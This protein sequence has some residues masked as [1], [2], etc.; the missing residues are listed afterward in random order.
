M[1]EPPF[2]SRQKLR[3]QHEFCLLIIQTCCPK[4]QLQRVSFG[5]VFDQL[6]SPIVIQT[7][8]HSFTQ[9]LWIER[10]QFFPS[11]YRQHVE[12]MIRVE[13]IVWEEIL[14]LPLSGIEQGRYSHTC[15]IKKRKS[16]SL[17]T[18]LIWT[19]VVVV[20]TNKSFETPKTQLNGSRVL[21]TLTR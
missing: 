20:Q 18:A 3:H 9:S 14:F 1:R 17:P 6:Y 10:F 8:K 12:A 21:K 13:G 2:D 19:R 4:L 16:V 7:L 5:H 11:E 15:T